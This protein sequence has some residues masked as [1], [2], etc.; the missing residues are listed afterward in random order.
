MEKPISEWLSELPEPYRSQALEMHREH[1]LRSFGGTPVETP[2]EAVNRAFLW[3]ATPQGR[4]YWDE[5]YTTLEAGS[6][7]TPDIT[8]IPCTW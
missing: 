8:E 2:H 4:A 7:P 5:L 6:L 1:P 3:E